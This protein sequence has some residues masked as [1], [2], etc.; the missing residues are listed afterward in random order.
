MLGTDGE[1]K[2]QLWDRL[3]GHYEFIR[4]RHHDMVIRDRRYTVADL[5]CPS[6]GTTEIISRPPT[7]PAYQSELLLSSTF[8]HFLKMLGEVPVKEERVFRL[9]NGEWSLW[10]ADENKIVT[11][12]VADLTLRH[13]VSSISTELRAVQLP[14]VDGKGLNKWLGVCFNKS[15]EYNLDFWQLTHRIENGEGM[16][17]TQGTSY[18][19]ISEH[20]H[21]GD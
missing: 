8:S 4:S 12:K 1:T 11:E 14:W 5:K 13:E 17:M 9:Q 21:E 7:D 19:K 3:P 10:N 6:T 15:V 18:L 16:E 20:Q 2:K